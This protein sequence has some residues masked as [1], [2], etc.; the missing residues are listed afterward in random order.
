VKFRYTIP[1]I[2]IVAG[3]VI[4]FGGIA[5]GTVLTHA[6]ASGHDP[7]VSGG[8]MCVQYGTNVVTYDYDDYACPAGS[9]LDQLTYTEP[10]P[11]TTV[12]APPA[13]ASDI[14]TI[15]VPVTYRN[16][17]RITG[18][19]GTSVTESFL[20][21]ATSSDGYSIR[22]WAAASSSAALTATFNNQRSGLLTLTATP[23]STAM[24]YE[25]TVWAT[26][27]NGVTGSASFPVTVQP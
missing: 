5:L 12:T 13:T 18:T 15:T 26:D 11:I 22:D 4:G 6:S 8:R 23:T 9:Y 16:E 7:A 24:T 14:V 2:A 17:L 20:L 3:A 25:V 19:A 10:S 21:T 27:S 1:A